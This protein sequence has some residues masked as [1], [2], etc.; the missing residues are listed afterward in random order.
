[1][2]TCWLIFV[3]KLFREPSAKNFAL[4]G[5][6]FGLTS[7]IRPTNFIAI[8]YLLFAEYNAPNGG[9]LRERWKFVQ[10][11]WSLIP[12]SGATVMLVWLPQMWYWHSVTGQW[13]YYSY[14]EEGFIN[15]RSPKILN[16]FCP[17]K[18]FSAFAMNPSNRCAMQYAAIEFI[19]ITT[20]MLSLVP[21]RTSRPPGR[22]ASP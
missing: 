16:V 20:S 7:L 10:K 1:M 11:N 14:D 21:A 9:T 3:P 13:F 4:A 8:L 17:R 12:I 19:P 18:V 2:L 5:L 15:W 22:R 6:I